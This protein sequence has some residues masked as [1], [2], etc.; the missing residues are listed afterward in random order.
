MATPAQPEQSS[1]SLKDK[2]PFLT[3]RR[4]IFHFVPGHK[5]A[6]TEIAP[7]LMLEETPLDDQST[8][9]IQ[10]RLKDTLTSNQAFDVEF[11]PHK[12]TPVRGLVEQYLASPVDASFIEVSQRLAA[13]LFTVQNGNNSPGLLAMMD[14]RLGQEQ[15]LVIVKLKSETGSR[16]FDDSERGHRRYRMEVLRDLFLTEGT[17]VFKSALFAPSAE[18]M[19]ILVCDDQRGSMRQYEVA[20]FFLEEFLGCKRLELGHVLT[21]RF[22]NAA[23][24]FLNDQLPEAQR[25]DL[26]D[27]IASQLRRRTRR[28]DVREFARDFVESSHRDSFVGFMREMDVP[29]VFDKDTSEISKYLRKKHIRTTHKIDIKIPEDAEQLVQVHGNR[30]VIHDTPKEVTGNA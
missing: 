3:V 25:N 13:T 2:V 1:S 6:T 17:R 27:D 19:K 20:L 18:E 16:L 29:L 30:I 10:Q 23:V 28:L 9:L 12:V 5:K 26:Y 11:N 4:A 24:D 8:H 22:Y 7:I 21:K 15:A 14:C